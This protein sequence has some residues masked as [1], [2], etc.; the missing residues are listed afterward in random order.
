MEPSVWGGFLAG[1]KN[2]PGHEDHKNWRARLKFGM[3]SLSKLPPDLALGL[4]GYSLRYILRDFERGVDLI[5]SITPFAGEPEGY[6]SG[7]DFR[8]PDNQGDRAAKDEAMALLCACDRCEEEASER[9]RTIN[10]SDNAQ[11]QQR[12]AI[13]A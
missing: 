1:W 12:G 13:T 3:S 8:R 9:Q 11:G 2:L 6:E 10:D 4:I 5:R 7:Q